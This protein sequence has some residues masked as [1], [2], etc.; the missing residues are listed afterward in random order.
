MYSALKHQGKALYTYA[1][2]GIEIPR[3]PRCVT[4]Y[5]LEL[6]QFSGDELSVT[7]HC[8]KGTYIRILGEDIGSALGCGAHMIALRRTE[9]GRFNLR[10]AL[11]LTQLEEM[12]SDQRDAVLLPVDSLL[13]SLDKVTLSSDGAF[14]LGQGQA[15]WQAGIVQTGHVRLYGPDQV[16]LGLGEITAEGKIAPKRLVV[17]NKSL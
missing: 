4:I 3:E 9:T 2:A 17:Q 6:D 7:V 5:R 14:Y 13:E 1:R 10:N 16:F 8:S 11:T 12:S 15:I